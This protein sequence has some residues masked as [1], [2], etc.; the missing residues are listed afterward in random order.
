[1]RHIDKLTRTRLLALLGLDAAAA[2]VAVAATGAFRFDVFSALVAVV[3]SVSAVASFPVVRR[4]LLEEAPAETATPASRSLGRTKK[5]LILAMCAGAIAYLGGSGTFAIF[6]AETTNSGNGVTSGTLALGNTNNTTSTTCYSYSGTV[7]YN[8]YG[9][10]QPLW[11][12]TGNV[13]PGQLAQSKLTVENTGSVDASVFYLS[14]PWPRTTLAS[15]ANAGSPTTI[16]VTAGNG[17]TSTTLTAGSILQISYGSWVETLT[18]GSVGATA[19]GNTTINISS[20]TLVHNYPTGARVENTGANTTAA[21]TECFDTLT[22]TGTVPV[23]G[24]TPGTSLPFVSTTN[25]PLCNTLLFWIQEQKTVGATTINYCWFGLAGGPGQC[26][27]PTTAVLGTAITT[28]PTSSITFQGGLSGNIKSGDTLSITDGT[29]T[30]TFKASADAYIGDTSVA[31][32]ATGGGTW[33]PAFAFA[34]GST[35]KD[36]TATSAL[37]SDITDT[38]SNFDTLRRANAPIQLYPLTQNGVNLRLGDKNLTST[39]WLNKHGD[40]GSQ[41]VFYIGTYMPVAAGQSQNQLQGLISTFSLNWH[42]EQ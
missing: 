37:D 26:R 25:N 36:T 40:N 8:A 41:R 5:I 33:T 17:F 9:S 29:N 13:A 16:L 4:W 7:V 6:T 1:M 39:V 34:V 12:T 19:G 15:P 31:V 11:N 27:T 18:V 28:S 3:T 20:G 21:N 23:A 42:I 2:L 22:T 14:A 30:T 38:I 35:I 10:C 24:A 32:Q